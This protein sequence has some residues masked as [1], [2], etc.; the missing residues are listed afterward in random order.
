MD[1]EMCYLEP[2]VARSGNVPICSGCIESH[3]VIHQLLYLDP[4]PHITEDG[5]RLTNEELKAGNDYVRFVPRNSEQLA[6]LNPT[7]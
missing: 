5:R 4:K 3:D 7:N 6:A 1:C 2:A